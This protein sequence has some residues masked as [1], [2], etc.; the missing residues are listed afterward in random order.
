MNGGSSGSDAQ[1]VGAALV[2]LGILGL[3][4]GVTTGWGSIAFAGHGSHGHLVGLFADT[5]LCAVHAKR[6]TILPKDLLLARRI[7]GETEKWVSL[8]NGGTP[9]A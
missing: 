4:P 9:W 2:A 7:R 6:I 3:V 8:H 1:V 5:L